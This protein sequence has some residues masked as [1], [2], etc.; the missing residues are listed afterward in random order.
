MLAEN[1]SAARRRTAGR[2]AAEDGVQ[3]LDASVAEGR[4][5]RFPLQLLLWRHFDLG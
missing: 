4:L 5:E 2:P 1:S 3:P